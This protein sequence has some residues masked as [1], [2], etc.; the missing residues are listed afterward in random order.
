MVNL[1]YLRKGIE[2]R[3]NLERERF[4]AAI[5]VDLKD[6]RKFSSE[7]VLSRIVDDLNHTY[8][9]SLVTPFS[10]RMGD[11]IIGAVANFSDAFLVFRDLYHQTKLQ[12]VGL[13]VGLGFGMIDTEERIDVHRVNGSAIRSAITARDSYVKQQTESSIFNKHHANLQFFTYAENEMIPYNALNHYLHYILEKWEMRTDKQN[14]IINLLDENQELTYK[15]IGNLLG[16]PQNAESNISRLLTRAD[17]RLVK[18][19]EKSLLDLLD[20][21]QHQLTFKRKEA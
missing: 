19:A 4:C 18:D 11:E 5:A 3:E 1:S 8:Q 14:R 21:L 2:G 17:Y 12:K 6:S 10:V 13:Y 9:Q 15:E 20:F 7:K 16:Q